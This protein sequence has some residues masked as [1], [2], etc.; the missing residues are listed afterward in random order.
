MNNLLIGFVNAG[1]DATLCEILEKQKEPV[2]FQDYE[3]VV[4]EPETR[5]II[6]PGTNFNP[7][8]D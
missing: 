2:S 8:L 1:N 5:P 3:G 6:L 7:V 4:P